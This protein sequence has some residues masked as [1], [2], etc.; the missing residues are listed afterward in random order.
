M[1]D[2][3]RIFK[4]VHASQFHRTL[5]FSEDGFLGLILSTAFRNFDLPFSVQVLSFSRAG[6]EGCGDLSDLESETV[7]PSLELGLPLL[8]SDFGLGF[9]DSED[10]PLD[11][12]LISLLEERRVVLTRLAD[13]P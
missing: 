8:V 12:G 2:L 10:C 3:S 9:V 13:F 1:R 7:W 5:S 6:E 4:Y 11:V